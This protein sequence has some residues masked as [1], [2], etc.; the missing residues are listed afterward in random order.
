M[1]KVYS[2]LLGLL[3]NIIT[4]GVG[5]MKGE[6]FQEKVL[7]YLAYLTQNVTEVR[8][9]M[10]DLR[11]EVTD[12]RQEVTDLRKTVVRIE[13]EHGEKLSVLFDGFKLHTEQL[14]RIEEKVSTHD[15]YILKRIK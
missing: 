7:E 14:N 12:L 5:R 10:K 9:E 3:Y 8:L 6:N 4:R 11:Q 2:V 13:K 1:K 15:E